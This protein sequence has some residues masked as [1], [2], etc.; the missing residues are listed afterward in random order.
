V[1]VGVVTA[2]LALWT[3]L[4]DNDDSGWSHRRAAH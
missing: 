4:V 1:I 3:L 2:A